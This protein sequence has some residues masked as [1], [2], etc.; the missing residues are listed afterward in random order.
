MNV[1]KFKAVLVEKD[2]SRDE[3]AS[4]WKCTTRTV[5]N[6]LT[7]KSPINLDE[8]QAFSK[9]AGLTDEEKFAIFM[10]E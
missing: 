3:L 5:T 9:R 10:A 6:K 2:I 4:L 8:A 1:P 7:G